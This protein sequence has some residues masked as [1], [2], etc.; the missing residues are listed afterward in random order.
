MADKRITN[1]WLA[2]ELGVTDITVSRWRTNKVQPSMNQ[3]VEIAKL[4]NVTVD[5]LL[6]DYNS[7]QE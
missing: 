5:D 6:E 7:K 3:F 4:L 2:N 1:I